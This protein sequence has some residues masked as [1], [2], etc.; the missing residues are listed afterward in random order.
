MCNPRT[1][2]A[3]AGGTAIQGWPGLDSE[4]Q[5]SQEFI[6]RLCQ[7]KEGKGKRKKEEKEEE[8][9]KE[10]RRGGEDKTKKKKKKELKIQS[11]TPT[12]R[13]SRI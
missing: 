1:R 9:E 12:I 11:L 10:G 5:A 13:W 4:F 3:E 8:E 2:E 6:T 7:K